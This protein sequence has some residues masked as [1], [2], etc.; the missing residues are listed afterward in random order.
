VCVLCVYC[1]CIVVITYYYIC[2][3]E[4]ASKAY[5]VYLRHP[6]LPIPSDR[7]EHQEFERQ[8]LIA[9]LEKLLA[10]LRRNTE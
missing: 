4:R 9:R 1:V 5:E 7:T 3:I 10:M 6:E 8:Q 2:F